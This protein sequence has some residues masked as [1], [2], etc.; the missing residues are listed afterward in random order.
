PRNCCRVHPLVNAPPGKSVHDKIR[1]AIGQNAE[2]SGPHNRGVIERRHRARLLVKPPAF[3]R[4][5]WSLV[6][7]WRA[8]SFERHTLA[9]HQILQKLH[10]PQTAVTK[11]TND[12][13]T[14]REKGASFTHGWLRSFGKSFFFPPRHGR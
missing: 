3:F 11:L 14:T 6:W 9:R 12:F 4:P 2:I 8:Q 13:I 1:R 10:N 5:R 7:L